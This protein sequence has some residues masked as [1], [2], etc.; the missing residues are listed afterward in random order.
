MNIEEGRDEREVELDRKGEEGM[1]V[2]IDS[3]PDEL[4]I[5]GD[6]DDLVDDDDVVEEGSVWFRCWIGLID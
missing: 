1:V 6:D 5:D 2:L 3:F 4:G